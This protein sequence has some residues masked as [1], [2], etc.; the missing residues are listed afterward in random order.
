MQIHASTAIAM[1]Q[2]QM[3]AYRR[4]MESDAVSYGALF[5]ILIEEFSDSAMREALARLLS[6]FAEKIAKEFS[7][8]MDSIMAMVDEFIK[9][10]PCDIKS[11][12]KKENAAA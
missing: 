4:R 2:L 7:I 12:L 3:L 8:P 1:L 9:A 5:L 11:C 10:L 6:M